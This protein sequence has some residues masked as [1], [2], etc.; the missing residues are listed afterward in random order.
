MCMNNVADAGNVAAG[1]HG[2]RTKLVG[3]S[4]MK[5]CYRRTHVDDVKP[6]I[7]SRRDGKQANTS[8]FWQCKLDAAESADPSRLFLP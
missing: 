6:N 7:Y 3:S 8:T 5:G 4:V 2:N 1:C